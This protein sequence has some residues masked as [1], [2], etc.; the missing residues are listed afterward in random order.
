M[1]YCHKCGTKLEEDAR[2]CYHCGTPV[3]AVQTR[4]AY[5]HH[6]KRKNP[7]VISA[8]VIAAI[9]LSVL[10]IAAILAVPF[11]PVNFIKTSQINQPGVDHLSLDFQADVAEVNV[12]TNLTDNAVLIN[13]SAT[14]S[15]SIFG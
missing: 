14:G 4:T 11:Y 9:L 12:F 8:I 10:I 15:T 1:P 13:V 6:P 5:D 3:V 2:F 7:L